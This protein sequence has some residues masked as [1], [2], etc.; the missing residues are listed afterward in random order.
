MYIVYSKKLNLHFG[1]N[2]FP[3][4]VSRDK[5]KME[6][7]GGGLTRAPP[8]ICM[9]TAEGGV[10]VNQQRSCV[11]KLPL[12]VVCMQIWASVRVYI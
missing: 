5:P 9:Q 2:I 11:Y 8:Y 10:E 3:S 12:S 1:I 6:N 4:A 7:P